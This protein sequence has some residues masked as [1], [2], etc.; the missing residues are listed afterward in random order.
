MTVA[1]HA[2]RGRRILVVALAFGT[3]LASAPLEAFVIQTYQGRRVTYQVKWANSQ[4]I[5]VM[6]NEAGT[7][8]LP[9]DAVFR[10][11]RESFAVW[12]AVPTAVASFNDMGLSSRDPNP[13]DGINVI[14]FDQDNGWLDLPP[15]SGVIAVTLM[16]TDPFSRTV[17]DSDIVFNDSQWRFVI[18]PESGSST[19]VLKDVMVHEVGHLLG[20]DHTPLSG[21][22]SVRPT[23][24]PFYGSDGPGEA[25]SL[26]ADDVAGVSQLYPTNGFLRETGGIAGAVADEEGNLLFGVHV[27][28]E[29]LENGDRISTLSGAY[30]DGGRGDYQLLGLPA[31]HYRVG[32]EPVE[33]GISDE[34]FGGIFSG[35][36]VGFAP[37][38]FDNSG[39]SHLAM[40][41]EVAP[42]GD[43]GGIDFITGL[44][45]DPVFLDFQVAQG[46]TPDQ[47]GPYTVQV[48]AENV[49]EV[50]LT[51]RVD[52]G[53]EE[54]VEMVAAGPGIFAASIP[55]QLVG[56]RVEY[57]ITGLG[58]DGVSASF[59]PVWEGFDIIELTGAPAAYVAL[60]EEDALSIV[61]TDSNRELARL[62]MG[63]EPIQ[64]LLDSRGSRLFVSNIGSDEVVVVE[65]S[66]FRVLERIPVGSEPLDMALSAD[67]GTLYVGN[68]GGGSITAIDVNTLESRVA[69][70]GFDSGPYG[71]AATA[72]HLYVADID[73]DRLHV[74]DLAEGDFVEA[75]P[76]PAS[77]RSLALN[78]D[79]SL[80][81]STSFHSSEVAVVSTAD[82]ELLDIFSLPISGSFAV[83]AGPDGQIFV[84]AHEDGVVL[85]VDG[86]SGRP[87]QTIEVGNDPRGISVSPAGDRVFVT[88][89]ESDEIVVFDPDDGR[90]LSSFATGQ[91]PRGVA[92]GTPPPLA[93]LP[94]VETI[95]MAAGVDLPG[96]FVLQPNFP[97]PFNASTVI[98]YQVIGGSREGRM[99]ELAVYNVLGHRVR[100]LVR[101]V[102]AA[103][104]FT[105]E[106]DGR[107]DEG[108]GA[109]SG[110]YVLVMRA[111]DHR[112]T[113]RILLLH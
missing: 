21:A 22:P 38:F 100:T 112:E 83:A 59:P 2:A 45:P 10:I 101:R 93:P 55:G 103:G 110:V 81:F 43:V 49:N 4:S 26:E 23:M 95:V 90:I 78:P 12:E 19:V 31:G 41:L 51:Y 105:T 29:N 99:V 48:R 111:V 6:L 1:D 63:S 85:I 97:N 16:E 13:R 109:A 86:D 70:S 79:G 11:L 24:N 34:N 27:I 61:D 96:A 72:A 106:W 54:V 65:T 30:P 94:D 87:L 84:T 57:Q 40:A 74:L 107:D 37:E 82:N 47:T 62:H 33:G 52:G 3:L 64:V 92:V 14:A 15:G 102:H 69:A 44:L 36:A 53:T 25:S 8:D 66:T 56:A 71:L 46:N 42:G 113:R 20:L 68:S 77:P 104:E 98:D 32:I 91:N 67:G 39:Q 73:N 9:N 7:P 88:N 5:P 80:L 17:T 76:M 108:A 18:E 35:F 60:R 58:D 50:L 75:I 28:A 89:A